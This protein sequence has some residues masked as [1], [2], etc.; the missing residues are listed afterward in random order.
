MK[1]KLFD[2]NPM[3]KQYI[4]SYSEKIQAT[5]SPF[6][7][8]HW[9]WRKSFGDHSFWKIYITNTYVIIKTLYRDDRWQLKT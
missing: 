2:W 6:P 5:D 9:T 4:N 7:L 8:P 3:F 1:A